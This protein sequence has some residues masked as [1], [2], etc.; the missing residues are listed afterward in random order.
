MLEPG[1]LYLTKVY[2]VLLVVQEQSMAVTSWMDWSMYFHSML[3][4]SPNLSLDIHLQNPIKVAS[5]SPLVNLLV[6]FTLLFDCYLVVSIEIIMDKHCLKVLTVLLDWCINQIVRRPIRPAKLILHYHLPIIMI[7]VSFPVTLFPLF[8]TYHTKGLL[9]LA[10][11]ATWGSS[12]SHR[13]KRAM[14][15]RKGRVIES[16]SW[17]LLGKTNKR[18][19]HWNKRILCTVES[20]ERYQTL[21]H[22]PVFKITRAPFAY[23]VIQSNGVSSN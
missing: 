14:T 7:L 12:R 13:T 17:S 23:H 18:K 3:A 2:I 5:I 16:Y 11:E 15:A 4:H 9:R 19:S 21:Y 8:L 22:H 1:S 20:K 6:G 10:C